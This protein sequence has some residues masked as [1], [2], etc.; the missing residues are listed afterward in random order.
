MGLL[1]AAFGLLVLDCVVS[2]V[3]LSLRHFSRAKLALLAE[4]KG[5]TERCERLFAHLHELTLATAT[6]RTAANLGIAL[7]VVDMVGDRLAS[8]A[9]HYASAFA[10]AAILVLVFSVAIPNAWARHAGEPLL[11][12]T[13]PL[14]N[15]LRWL[16]SPLVAFLHL[17]DPLVRRLAGAPR[18]DGQNGADQ[19]EQEILAAVSEGEAA[20]AV[21][22]EEKEMIEKIIELDEM[23]AGEIM[24]PRTDMIALP[25]TAT[26]FEAKDLIAREG[27]SR[28][29]VYDESVDNVLGVLYAKDLLA[30]DRTDDFDIIKVMR[31]VP[32]VPETKA[33]RDLLRE[34]RENKVHLAIVL[35]EYGGTAGLV[36]IED[37]MEEL[38][39][40]I[41]DEFEPPEPEP[42][43]QIDDDTLEV[44][45]KVHVGEVNDELDIELPE[46]EEYDTIGGFVLSTLGRI[47]ET[48]YEFDHEDV[49]IRVIDAEQRKINRLQIHVARTPQ[50][51]ETRNEN[52][53]ATS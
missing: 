50:P 22:E 41:V 36:T 24:T 21:D 19:H 25:S 38:V 29:P 44:D 40:E 1:G 7:V 16:L 23:H 39:G 12:A 28:I 10:V 52:G 53:A 37:I 35:D 11:L 26:L 45:A 30:F 32:F 6:I 48:G 43:R 31:T 34:F 9:A 4:Q 3:N 13:A 8:P 2:A 51:A 46:S 47:P 42:I 33:L 18:D 20:G 15:T 17:F 27:H 49:H 5:L 14:L